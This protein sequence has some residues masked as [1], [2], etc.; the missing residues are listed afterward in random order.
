MLDED[1]LWR[2][3]EL[4][5]GR[6]LEE[7]GHAVTPLGE[8]VG[9]TARSQAPLTMVGGEHLRMDGLDGLD[10]W[11]RQRSFHDSRRNNSAFLLINRLAVAAAF[12]GLITGR[13]GVNTI[14]PP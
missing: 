2:R 11:M 9:N 7:S 8:A 3:C 6:W 1:A 10:R 4:A 13:T 12:S 5:W 14:E